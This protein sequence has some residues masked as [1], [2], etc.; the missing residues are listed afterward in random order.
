MC[1]SLPTLT[2]AAIAIV[3]YLGYLNDVFFMTSIFSKLIIWL[4]H[5]HPAFSGASQLVQAAPTSGLSQLLALPAAICR[6]ISSWALAQ[7]SFSTKSPRW[8]FAGGERGTKRWGRA[9]GLGWGWKVQ[10][11]SVSVPSI[12]EIQTRRRVEMRWRRA[13]ETYRLCLYFRCGV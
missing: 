8:T 12:V 6:Q 5:H 11:G 10:D 13:A 3:S 4:L 1:P 7:W 9:Q 2:L